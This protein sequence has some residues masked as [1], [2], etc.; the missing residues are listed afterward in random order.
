MVPHNQRL[1]INLE[2]CL[3][4]L[5]QH[6]RRYLLQTLQTSQQN[7]YLEE[8]N[9][10]KVVICLDSKLLQILSLVELHN[11]QDQVY[12]VDLTN[13][14]KVVFLVKIFLKQIK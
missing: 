4:N 5:I 14:I 3:D 11:Q 9:N 12:L 13:K 6:K 2:V 8:I 1:L 10:L 7:L